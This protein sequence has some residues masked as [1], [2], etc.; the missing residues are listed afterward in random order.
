MYIYT[1][2]RGDS[3]VWRICS[4]ACVDT[5]G[6]NK[7]FH[8]SFNTIPFV[9]ARNRTCNVAELRAISRRLVQYRF[10]PFRFVPRRLCSSAAM[11]R[12]I[13]AVTIAAASKENSFGNVGCFSVAPGK[14]A[15]GRSASCTARQST[16]IYGKQVSVYSTRQY[17]NRTPTT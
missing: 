16:P 6:V 9:L 5:V 8:I 15:S 12:A 14:V 10:V 11:S 7:T 13:E 3:M 1:V 17:T 2:C 4:Y